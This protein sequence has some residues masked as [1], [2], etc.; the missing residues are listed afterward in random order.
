M[1][2]KI[3]LVAVLAMTLPLV[4]LM[5]LFS[6]LGN[7]QPA[8]ISA[9][10]GLDNDYD[11]IGA[12]LKWHDWDVNSTGVVTDDFPADCLRRTMPAQAATRP[13]VLSLIMMEPCLRPRGPP[14]T[15]A[16]ASAGQ[17]SA[18]C[19]HPLA[20]ILFSLKAQHLFGFLRPVPDLHHPTKPLLFR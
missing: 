2:L 18:G 16:L 9:L 4:S 5:V 11:D 17:L 12:H 13:Q 6:P 3:A 14:T 1:N 10:P 20:T 7:L 15:A 8:L 19:H